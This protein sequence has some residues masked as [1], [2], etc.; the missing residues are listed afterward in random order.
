MARGA[1]RSGRPWRRGRYPIQGYG[2]DFHAGVVADKRQAIMGLLC[3][4]VV[5]VFFDPLGDFLEAQQRRLPF[6]GSKGP[7]DI[8]D[9]RVGQHLRSWQEAL[10][11]RPRVVRVRRFSLPEWGVGIDDLP[12]HYLEFLENPDEF[13]E[14]DVEMIRAWQEAGQ[15]VFWWAK[16][17]WM[18]R[19]GRVEST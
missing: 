3:P 19:S 18:D 4:N 8:Y 17:Y 11:F 12:T 2:T 16:D 13:P 9:A 14:I 7:Y 10:G 6:M 1:Q 5:A 15:F